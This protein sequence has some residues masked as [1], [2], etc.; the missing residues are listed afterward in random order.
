MLQKKQKRQR[1]TR[2]RIVASEFAA[3]RRMLRTEL[4]VLGRYCGEDEEHDPSDEFE[5]YLSCAVCG[6][7]GK[8]FRKHHK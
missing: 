7:H 6:D 8:F 4:T 3:A 5:E 1:L 2:T